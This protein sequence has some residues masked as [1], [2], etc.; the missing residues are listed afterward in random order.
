MDRKQARALAKTT[1]E[2]TGSYALVVSGPVRKLGGKSPAAAIISKG[3]DLSF[4]ARDEWTLSGEVLISIYV[5]CTIGDE[6]A[7]ED[8]L[9]NLTTG[10][11]LALRDA[12]F[13]HMTSDATPESAPLRDLDGV[14]Y[15]VERLRARMDQD[16]E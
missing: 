13:T 4:D 5:R 7:A 1:L 2:G 8:Q 9:D 3:L 10:A 15:R 12:G 16:E 6:E 14:F 11:A